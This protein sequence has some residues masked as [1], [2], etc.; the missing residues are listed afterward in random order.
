MDLENKRPSVRCTLRTS[1]GTAET[2]SLERVGAAHPSSTRLQSTSRALVHCNHT[3][4]CSFGS[5]TTCHPRCTPPGKPR[6]PLSASTLH[7]SVRSQRRMLS[8]CDSSVACHSVAR[9]PSQAASPS[10]SRWQ[11]RWHNAPARRN[12]RDA[13]SRTPVTVLVPRPAPRPLVPSA[14]AKRCVAAV[15]EPTGPLHRLTVISRAHERLEATV[16]ATT[17]RAW[18]AS[19]PGERLT[20]PW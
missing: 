1:F 14:N 8:P 12:A 15:E 11:R 7:Q 10:T 13:P 19:P 17:E 20:L 6:G 2:P 3:C 5:C 4:W 9:K 18:R 16:A